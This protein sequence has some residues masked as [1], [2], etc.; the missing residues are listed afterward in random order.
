MGAALRAALQLVQNGSSSVGFECRESRRER[1]IGVRRRG[2]SL[3]SSCG[4]SSVK[5]QNGQEDV[6]VVRGR[7]DRAATAG[8]TLPSA[9]ADLPEA[10]AL[11]QT[12]EALLFDQL[13]DLWLDL[14]S[15]L[16]SE[17]K[18]T[19]TH[20]RIVSITSDAPTM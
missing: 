12:V 15:Q 14:L 5:G 17:K 4:Q 20:Q 16:S 6:W 10:G 11:A 9:T 18:D 8:I 3:P 19:H 1:L 2:F 13:H 7:L